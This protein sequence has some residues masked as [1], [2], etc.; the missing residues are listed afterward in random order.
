MAGM[1]SNPRGRRHWLSQAL[2]ILSLV[3][4]G[5]GLFNLG[6]A[7]WP[8]PS[9]GVEL[10]IKRGVLPGSPPARDYASGSN[11]RLQVSW[12]RWMRLGATGRIHV[13]LTDL[14]ES[15]LAD[16]GLPAQVVLAE[17]VIT[18]LPLNPPGQVQ[19]N[20]G[21][22]QDL[23]LSWEAEGMITGEYPGN[24]ILAFGFFDPLT[25]QLETVPVALINMGIR[26]VDLWGLESGMTVWFGLVSL[27]LWGA[28]FVAGRVV[29]GSQ[30]VG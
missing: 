19:A 2:F 22:Q 3:F 21:D 6:W 28:L 12:P 4:L 18:G 23:T 25:D 7:V 8:A 14:D 26:V 1:K 17:P 20:L 29:Q 11:Y 5:F 13:V 30:G 9:D 24:M 27:V 16:I 15:E 10:I